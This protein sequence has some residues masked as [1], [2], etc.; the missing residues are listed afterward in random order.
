MS[1]DITSAIIDWQLQKEGAEQHF[2]LVIY[3][4]L[5]KLASENRKRVLL[6]FGDAAIQEH[7]NSTTSLV[8][9]LY[10]RLQNG[11]DE[12]YANRKEFFTMVARSIHNVLV[13]QARKTQANKR[14]A[15]TMEYSE[16]LN[17]EIIDDSDDEFLAL[18]EAIE[19]L[20]VEFPRQAQTVKLKYF[21]GLLVKEISEIVGISVSSA[22]KD[23]AFAKSWLKTQL[24]A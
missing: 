11:N 10:I 9:E 19:R 16:E 23:M 22:E 13:D 17:D 8:H 18:N 24:S 4:H 20:E 21:G 1:V 6:K 14:N 7:V 3:D 2:Y 15:H 5:R 12:F